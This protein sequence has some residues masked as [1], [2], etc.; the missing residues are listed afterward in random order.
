VPEVVAVV[1]FRHKRRARIAGYRRRTL[2]NRAVAS[3]D[4]ATPPTW[5]AWKAQT[6]RRCWRYPLAVEWALEWFVYRLRSLA[7]F[8][9]LELAG[10][11]T[12]VVAIVVW[13]LEADQR[14]KQADEAIKAR[15][16]RAWELINAARGSTWDGGR[17]D[18]LQD[19]NRDHV[20]LAAAP[21]EQAY[22]PGVDLR[23]ANLQGANLESA[24]LQGAYLLHARLRGANLESADFRAANLVYANLL[25]AKNLTP[26]QLEE[27]KGHFRTV[28]PKGLTPP[29]HWPKAGRPRAGRAAQPDAADATE[30]APVPGDAPGPDK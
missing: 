22:L 18:A 15:H 26:Q 1:R 23:G 5:R 28:L 30:H 11:L 10:K 17:I 8:D 25:E 3:P 4:L 9:L 19:L 7:L 12:V 27:A 20:S 21:L 29:T 13:F 2:P 6:G 14:A 16:Y 24:N